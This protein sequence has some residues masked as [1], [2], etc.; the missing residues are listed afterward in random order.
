MDHVRSLAA[1][2]LDTDTQ[3]GKFLRAAMLDDRFHAFVGAGAAPFPD[4][5]MAKRQVNVIIDNQHPGIIKSEH[6]LQFM[7]SQSRFIHVGHRFDQYDRLAEERG[8]PVLQDVSHPGQLDIMA[9]ANLV[10]A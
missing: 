1:G 4:P 6:F 5:D 9:P 8:F 3:A 2:I 10:D 7:H